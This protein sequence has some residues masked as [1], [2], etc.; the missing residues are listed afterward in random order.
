MSLFPSKIWKKTFLHHAAS[1]SEHTYILIYSSFYLYLYMYMHIHLQVGIYYI[2]TSMYSYNPALRKIWKLTLNQYTLLFNTVFFAVQIIPKYNTKLSIFSVSII[3]CIYLSFIRGENLMSGVTRVGS[4]VEFNHWCHILLRHLD[5]YLSLDSHCPS[6]Q[7]VN[8]SAL[9]SRA[10][11]KAI[12]PQIITRYL[13]IAPL[14]S[15]FS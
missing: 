11:C 2:S 15:S 7:D 1:E 5:F 4:S 12:I 13:I 8:T 3:G 9:A 10:H 6:N 14:G